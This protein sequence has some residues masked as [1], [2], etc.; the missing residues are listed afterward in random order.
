[1]MSTVYIQTLNISW[2]L[3]EV[4]RVCGKNSARIW[5]TF[6]RAGPSFCILILHW[7]HLSPF[8]SIHALFPFMNHSGLLLHFCSSQL[9]CE[10]VTAIWSPLAGDGG[11]Q[12]IFHYRNTAQFS[13]SP[14]LSS[15]C[16]LQTKA[17]QK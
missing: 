13:M 14:T 9:P 10:F 15:L 11:H 6:L 4:K 1:M 2:F 3:T 17:V 7:A 12:R 8:T 16:C 5:M